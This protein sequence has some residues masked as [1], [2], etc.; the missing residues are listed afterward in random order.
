MK[1]KVSF[2]YKMAAIVS[3][4]SRDTK[5]FALLVYIMMTSENQPEDL[6]EFLRIVLNM[7]QPQINIAR[8]E[9]AAK[10]EDW[11]VAHAATES[12]QRRG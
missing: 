8:S 3:S 9:L 4:C 12:V 5:R 7:T 2:D 1:T 6:D 10:T 11:N